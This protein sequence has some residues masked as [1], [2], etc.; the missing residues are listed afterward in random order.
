[1]TVGMIPDRSPANPVELEAPRQ[2]RIVA[3]MADTIALASPKVDDG[4]PYV[5]SRFA[6]VV[7]ALAANPYQRVWGAAGEP[8]LPVHD[9]SFRTVVGGLFPRQF[10]ADSMR[11]LDSRIDLRWGAD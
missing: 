6:D 2:E 1:M 7:D 11:T 10:R 4:G 8:P 3:A 5:G 9:V